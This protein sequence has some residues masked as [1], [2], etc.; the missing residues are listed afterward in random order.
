MVSPKIIVLIDS[1]EKRLEKL[2]AKA[3]QTMKQL[4]E[5]LDRTERLEQ[6][7]NH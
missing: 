6:S 4:Q 2:E 1:R 7:L 3:I 5:V